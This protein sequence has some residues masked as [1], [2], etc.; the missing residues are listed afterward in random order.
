MSK[1]LHLSLFCDHDLTIENGIVNYAYAKFAKEIPYEDRA[2]HACFRGYQM[3]GD[4]VRKCRGDKFVTRG[5]WSNV[6]PQCRG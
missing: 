4:S 6:P 5:K 3:Y 2:Y 1:V